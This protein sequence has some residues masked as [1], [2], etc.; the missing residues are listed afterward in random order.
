MPK[1]EP[2]LRDLREKRV[3]KR[4]KRFLA[5]P[6]NISWQVLGS[7]APGAPRSLLLHTDHRR[8]LHLHLHLH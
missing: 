2:H 7:G 3:D 6:A 8:Y 1:E 5:Q 4:S